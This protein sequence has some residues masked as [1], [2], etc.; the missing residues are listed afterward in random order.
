MDSIRKAAVSISEPKVTAR[1]TDGS[2]AQSLIVF[3]AFDQ[4]NSTRFATTGAG[5]SLSLATG[6]S[7]VSCQVFLAPTGDEVKGVEYEDSRFTYAK[8]G[9]NPYLKN[10]ISWSK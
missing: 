8:Y 9:D 4:C 10:P 5:D 7:M 6:S 3:G 2:D 1:L